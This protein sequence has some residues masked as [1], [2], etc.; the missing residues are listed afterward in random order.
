KELDVTTGLYDKVIIDHKGERHPQIIILNQKKEVLAIYTIPV[1]AHI[2]V[3]DSQKIQAGTLLAKTPR[4]ISKTTDITGGLP[5]VAELFEARRPKDPAIISEIDGTVEFGATKKGQRRIVITASSG[6]KK[7]YLIPH[8]KHLNVYKGDLVSSGQKLVDGPVVP[9][10]ILQVL[11]DKKLQEYLVNEIQEVYRLQGV[12]IN[13]KHIET[14]VRQMLKKVIIEDSGDTN[15]L[16][17][18]QVDKI[19][20]QEE[21][22]RVSKKGKKPAQAKP[23]LLGITKASLSMESFISAAS[24][25]ETTRVLTDAA[26]SGR[27]DYLLGLKENVIMGHL[28]PAGTGFHAHRDITMTKK[29]KPIETRQTQEKPEEKEKENN[30]ND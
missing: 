10:D 17:G 16:I 5:R 29:G 30:A 12:K 1:G 28:I 20:F 7:E 6:M 19:K 15:F 9:Q 23:I 27:R 21:N 24:F 4:K 25:Q 26:A 14:I 11:G 8:G 22:E 2:V 13:D 3:K 18:M